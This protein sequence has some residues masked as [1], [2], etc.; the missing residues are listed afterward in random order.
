MDKKIQT[1][2]REKNR[3]LNEK[4]FVEFVKNTPDYEIAEKHFVYRNAK[5]KVKMRHISCG[6]EWEVRISKFMNDGSRCPNPSCFA[7]ER[8]LH[9]RKSDEFF[10]KIRDK[11]EIVEPNFKYASKRQ[12]VRLKHLLCGHEFAPIIDNI[13]RE[14]TICP[15]CKVDNR[16]DRTHEKVILV[17]E[18]LP[19]YSLIDGEA[20]IKSD[21][22]IA[23]K[24]EKCGT[25]FFPTAHNFKDNESRCPVCSGRSSSKAEKE[26]VEW[27]EEI[28]DDEIVQNTRELISPQELDI[29]IPSCKLAIEYNGLRWHSSQFGKDKDYHLN[30]TEKCLEKEIDLFHVFSDEWREKESIV[31]SMIQHR[32]GKTNRKIYA[33]K[34][35][36]K[37]LDSKSARAFFEKTH[38]SGY[39]NSRKTFA[40]LYEDEVVAALSLRKPWQKKYGNTIEI[41]RFSSELETAV[42]GGFQKLL[43]HSRRWALEEGFD[44]ILTYADRRFGTGNV[45]REAGF[46]YLGNT[47]C[48]YWYTD[49]L[50]RFG[51][52]R[53]RAKD[54]F[55]E[56][57]ITEEAGVHKVWGCGSCIYQMKLKQH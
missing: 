24:H 39:V 33:R 57:Q 6:T 50:N 35:V 44:S 13:L 4:R 42:I 52:F 54:G 47:Q 22:K 7:E 25:V 51:R 8:V 38:I 27:L 14:K 26:I 53:F 30:K 45:Y 56:K 17:F 19:E 46:E 28:C 37:D 48:D 9:L 2:K 12:R 15:K 5:Q 11:Y 10:E 29:F 55:T 49:G 43:K 16:K 34:C 21:N 40:L 41:A 23:V 18:N 20:Q 32:V 31:K 36:I 3:L 1:S